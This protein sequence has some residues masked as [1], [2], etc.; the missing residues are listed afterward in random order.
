MA[1]LSLQLPRRLKLGSG[2]KGREGGSEI[3]AGILA[4]FVAVVEQAAQR[5]VA[6]GHG[7]F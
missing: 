1:A 5:T 3:V 6:G 7:I 4:A 2:A